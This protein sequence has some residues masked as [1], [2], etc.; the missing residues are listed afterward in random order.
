[1][2]KPAYFEFVTPSKVEKKHLFKGVPQVNHDMLEVIDTYH[3]PP[4]LAVS[5]EYPFSNYVVH[6][7]SECMHKRMTFKDESQKSVV[8]PHNFWSP[9]FI[10]LSTSVS[11]NNNTHKVPPASMSHSGQRMLG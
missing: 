10:Q 8:K 6:A 2:Y 11:D 5:N 1:M 4:A 3:H 9:Q 7:S